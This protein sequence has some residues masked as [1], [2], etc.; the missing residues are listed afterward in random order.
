M[1]III[2]NHKD[3]LLMREAIGSLENIENNCYRHRI[4]NIIKLK[5]EM[6]V[7]IVNT[8]GTMSEKKKH[9]LGP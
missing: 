1:K 7:F 9:F 8:K 4:S 5:Y 2:C 6:L 3:R